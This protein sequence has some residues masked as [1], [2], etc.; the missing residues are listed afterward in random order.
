MNDYSSV[1]E[2]CDCQDHELK[3]HRY[4]DLMLC[5]HCY[6]MADQD[7]DFENNW[8]DGEMD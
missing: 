3:Y 4:A 6:G 1:C 2:G 5:E 8:D 7:E